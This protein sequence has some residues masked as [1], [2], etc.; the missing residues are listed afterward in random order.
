[1]RSVNS[2]GFGRV[3]DPLYLR[4]SRE[5]AMGSSGR[6]AHPSRPQLAAPN[7]AEPSRPARPRQRATGAPGTVARA[8][9]PTSSAVLHGRGRHGPR[10][11]TCRRTYGQRASFTGRVA[12]VHEVLAITSPARWPWRVPD[13]EIGRAR[14][15]SRV[16]AASLLSS[17]ARGGYWGGGPQTSTARTGTTAYHRGPASSPGGSWPG[18]GPE[19]SCRSH[20]GDRRGD[21][22]DRR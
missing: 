20:I 1:M 17:R 21:R 4:C 18:T 2:G 14:A 12:H 19:T 22:R 9:P 6:S 13:G 10:Q 5:R 3:S 7:K 8:L 11:T 16:R 15:L